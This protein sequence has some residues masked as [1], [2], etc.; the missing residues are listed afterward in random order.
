MATPCK[1]ECWLHS[2]LV[3]GLRVQ[4]LNRPRQN[5][6]HYPP[7]LHMAR[8]EC[9]RRIAL[10]FHAAP[11]LL[12]LRQQQIECFAQLNTAGHQQH[13]R[14]ATRMLSAPGHGAQNR[15]HLQGDWPAVAT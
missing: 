1:H 6:L 11:K 9:I 3:A 7:R 15:H 2:P 13:I 8:M 10:D 5:A 4:Q 12:L 14:I